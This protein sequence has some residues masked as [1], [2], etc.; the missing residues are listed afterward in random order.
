[1]IKLDQE[2]IDRI[3]RGKL[4]QDSQASGHI[5]GEYGPEAS[6]EVAHSLRHGGVCPVHGV[7]WNMPWPANPAGGDYEYTGHVVVHRYPGTAGGVFVY[8]HPMPAALP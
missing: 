2:D 5:P 1:M 6:A 8:W 7:K 4:R 3:I